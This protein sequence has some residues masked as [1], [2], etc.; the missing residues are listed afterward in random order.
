MGWTGELQ[1]L[2]SGLA[3]LA[4]KGWHHHVLELQAAD[5]AL[6]TNLKAA[7]S[8]GLR[9]FEA[10]ERDTLR[11]GR[12]TILASLR[13]LPPMLRQYCNWLKRERL[14]CSPRPACRA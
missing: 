5:I 13:S 3:G 7:L 8:D 14:A 12:K 10:H 4:L 1:T 11:C 6:L 2:N 9:A